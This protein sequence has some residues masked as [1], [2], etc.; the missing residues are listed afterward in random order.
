MQLYFSPLSCSVATRI[1]LYEAGA[2]ATYIEVDSKTKRTQDG[3]DYRQ[4]HPLGLVPALRTD[5]GDV[6]TE[7]AAILQ[8]LA[9][10]LPQAGLAPDDSRGR[11][12]LQ[13]WLSFIGTELHKAT[14]SPLLDSKSPEGAR[15][16]ALERG[17]ARLAYLD[18]HLTGR[19]FLLERFSVADAYLVTVLGWCVAT[20]IELMKWPAL[21]AYFARLKDRPSV[22]KAFSEERRLYGAELEKRKLRQ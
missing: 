13:Q 16:Y 1:C 20:P 19:E 3:S 4:V 18:Q 2:E 7:N 14:F 5:D 11:T 6:L 9:Q 10:A 21:S 15:S 8:Y 17:T 22:A 12:R